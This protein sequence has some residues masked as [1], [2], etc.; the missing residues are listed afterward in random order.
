MTYLY[1]LTTFPF[2]CC[3]VYIE[4]IPKF[5]CIFPSIR[6]RR[7][8]RT[9]SFGQIIKGRVEVF[10][11]SQ[12]KR[13]NSESEMSKLNQNVCQ[14]IRLRERK[15][16]S[17]SFSSRIPWA[18]S[19]VSHSSNLSLNSITC[20]KS[21]GSSR[22]SDSETDSAEWSSSCWKGRENDVVWV[23]TWFDFLRLHEIASIT[24][25]AFMTRNWRSENRKRTQV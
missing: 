20:I 9:E 3:F 5:Y 18:S 11:K 7:R 6:E 8:W 22:L 1:P 24:F 15:T 23:K 13:G 4:P 21:S 12:G 17:P 25:K 14:D 2:L 16:D 10:W 19:S